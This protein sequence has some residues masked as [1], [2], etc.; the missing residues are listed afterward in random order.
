MFLDSRM[1]YNS[2][3]FSIWIFLANRAKQTS[4]RLLRSRRF[5]H[6]RT[7]KASHIECAD[8]SIYFVTHIASNK[9]L[10]SSA[11]K[12]EEGEK[13]KVARQISTASINHPSDKNALTSV[14]FLLLW[15][16]SGKFCS[17]LFSSVHK[18]RII[19]MAMQLSPRKVFRYSSPSV[20][21]IGDM[22][23]DTM[24]GQKSFSVSTRKHERGFF[25][26]EFSTSRI[27]FSIYFSPRWHFEE[28]EKQR[29]KPVFN[30]HPPKSHLD[31]KTCPDL[32]FVLFVYP[33]VNSSESF[34]LPVH[35]ASPSKTSRTCP[36]LHVNS[37]MSYV[38]RALKATQTKFA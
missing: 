2:R 17:P 22:L 24:S 18:T 35:I 21:H 11:E 9:F 4:P 19:D 29:T 16:A 3:N 23:K 20:R 14:F 1:F 10:L 8:F 27:C 36:W 6:T 5:V 25:K 7:K 31:R 34:S 26:K 37:V 32:S 13:E 30:V 28:K 33:L 12:S 38:A 15:S